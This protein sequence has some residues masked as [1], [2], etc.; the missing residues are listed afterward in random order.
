MKQ[1]STGTG[2]VVLSGTILA[3]VL[4]SSPRTATTA[5]ASTQKEISFVTFDEAKIVLVSNCPSED[6]FEQ[7][8]IPFDKGTCG[9]GRIGIFPAVLASE[10]I[11]VN[12][13]GILEHI[14]GIR[15]N[16]SDFTLDSGCGLAISKLEFLSNGRTQENFTCIWNPYTIAS[17]A[18][19]R[20]FNGMQICGW[21]D[22]DQD[23]DLDL[24]IRLYGSSGQAEY[25]LKNIGFQHTASLEGDLNGDGQVDAADLGRLLGGYTG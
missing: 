12:G 9:T 19:L 25:W 13:D 8:P 5:F 16:F 24:V 11:D 10:A 3:S 21:R 4:L 20:G 6:W 23:G 1:I 2:L 14:S 17:F 7:V 15:E 18:A 22:M